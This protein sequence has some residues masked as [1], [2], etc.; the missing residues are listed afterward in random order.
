MAVT[1]WNREPI[2]FILRQ[3]EASRAYSPI[4]KSHVTLWA[5]DLGPI[6][7]DP[8]RQ[9]VLSCAIYAYAQRTRLAVKA[10]QSTS[11]SD[12]SERRERR[13]T[14]LDNQL[15]KLL[16]VSR[17]GANKGNRAKTGLPAAP[18]LE[19]KRQPG[20]RNGDGTPVESLE[21]AAGTGLAHVE[22]E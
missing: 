3:I 16:R 4:V 17:I 19:N 22:D 5:Q 1:T 12:A 11:E 21:D 15:Q 2:R 20:D 9:A 14:Q 6:P 7:D 18:K 10:L 8:A 13:I